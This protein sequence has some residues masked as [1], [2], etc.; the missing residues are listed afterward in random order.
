MQRSILFVPEGLNDSSQVQS[1]WEGFI[2]DPSRRVRYDRGDI[3]NF[4]TKEALCGVRA[5][6][7]FPTGRVSV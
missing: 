4:S 2:D 1:A 3:G 7:P 5:F 6:I